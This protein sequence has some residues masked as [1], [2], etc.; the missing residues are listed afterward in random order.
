[1]PMIPV[2]EGSSACLRK[3]YL[4]RVLPRLIEFQPDFI[5]VSAGFDAH[6][7][8]HLHRPRETM[9]T[10]FDY[11]WVTEEL[12]KVANRFAGGR[13]V[14]VLEGGYNTNLGPL[15]PLA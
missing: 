9:I 6:E 10:E 2:L 8:D 4:K 1:V 15:S 14:S 5:L 3:A 13:M 12:V 7:K 11:Q